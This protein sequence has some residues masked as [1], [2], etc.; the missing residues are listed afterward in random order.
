MTFCSTR[1]LNSKST[2]KSIRAAL[3]DFFESPVIIQITK[4][5]FGVSDIDAAR[6]IEFHPRGKALAKHL[7][8]DDQIGDDE[9]RLALADARTTAPRQKFRVALNI[10]DKIEQLLLRV[11][12]HALLGVGR[13]REG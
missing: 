12:K 4:R 9:M 3:R 1:D 11:G 5:P 13:H 10:G 8:P 6:W 2:K 7:E